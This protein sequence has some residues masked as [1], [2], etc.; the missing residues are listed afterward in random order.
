MV[1]TRC[2]RASEH[3]LHRLPSTQKAPYRTGGHEMPPRRREFEGEMWEWGAVPGT[4]ERGQA[5]WRGRRTSPR[6]WRGRE[7][8]P[9]RGEW[10]WRGHGPGAAEGYG[11]E[12]RGGA[13]RGEHLTWPETIPG[14]GMGGG[15]IREEIRSGGLPRGRERFEAEGGWTPGS[16]PPGPRGR[17]KSRRRALAPHDYAEPFS[18]SRGSRRRYRPRRPRARDGR[19]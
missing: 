15:R 12:Y 3:R 11:W 6:V 7:A 10:Q 14:R 18:A 4:S 13:P 9:R 2:A 17:P 16:V 8:P 5:S 19:H 1:T